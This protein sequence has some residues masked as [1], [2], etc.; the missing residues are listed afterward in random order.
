MLSVKIRVIV[1]NSKFPEKL[2]SFQQWL[3]D[4]TNDLTRSLPK[5]F[6]KHNLLRI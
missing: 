2:S 5:G 6:Q 3:S 4:L 1:I